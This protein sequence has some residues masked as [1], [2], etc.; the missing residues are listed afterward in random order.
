MRHASPPTARTLALALLLAAASCT[1]GP[2]P[3]AS[4]EDTVVIA[5]RD[6][7]ETLFAPLAQSAEALAV[8]GAMSDGLVVEDENG[9]LEPRLAER[10]PTIE[11][12]DAALAK[13]PD[14]RSALNVRFRLRDGAR[15]QDGA[16]VRPADLRFGW[17]LFNN[18]DARAVQY[19]A[20]TRI[21]DVRPVDERTVEI[22]YKPGELDPRFALCCNAFLLPEAAL[23]DVPVTKLAESAFAR[24]P[25]YAG[26]FLFKERQGNVSITLERSQ[27]YALGPAKLRT[28]VFV[29]RP[30]ADAL[31]ADLSAH[32]VDLATAGLYGVDRAGALATIEPRGVHATYTPSLALEHLD[33]NLRDPS[34]LAKPH[35]ILGDGVVRA[36]LATAIDRAKLARNSTAGRSPPA[37]S[38][39]VPPSWAAA[40]AGDV[41]T[42]A[43]DA[44]AA[45][46]VLD[47]AGWKRGADGLRAREGRRLRLR[48]VVAAGNAVRDRAAE[49]I[50]GD[51]GRIGVEVTSESVSMANLTTASGALS[52]GQF[53][54]ALYAWVGDRDPYGWSLLYHRSQVPSATNGFTGQNYSGWSNERFSTLADEAAQS[55]ERD[56]RRQRYLEMQRIW[57]AALPALPLYQRTAVDVADAR[58]REVRPLPTRQPITW[59][60]ARWSFGGV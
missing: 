33:F 46:Q 18:R 21:Q 15:W 24:A 52:S 26:P 35:P 4:A 5:L 42:F 58:L 16:P 9:V 34:D 11:N 7:P 8:I 57:T 3:R 59:N 30:D 10:V 51:L 20:A 27:Y 45:E 49:Q 22:V 54:L 36:A 17:L 40:G 25:V 12:G 56:A 37:I 13:M 19:N 23:R 41:T 38:Y 39:L 2:G 55:L 53:D 48:L 14:G 43:F 32:R 50:A 29:F 6:E 28:V 1:V 44:A 60:V 31:L 47:S